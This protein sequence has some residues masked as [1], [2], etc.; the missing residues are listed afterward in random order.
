MSPETLNE[1]F[2]WTAIVG[3]LLLTLAV[4]RQLGLLLVGPRE[5]LAYAM[6]PKVGDKADARF[7]NLFPSID[8]SPWN[9]VIFAQEAC[10]ACEELLE[11]AKTQTLEAPGRFR[12]ALVLKG[13]P[14]FAERMRNEFPDVEM[15][16]QDEVLGS[17]EASEIR[18][19]PLAFLISSEGIV[20][21]KAIG[22]N[23]S[24]LWRKIRGDLPILEEVPA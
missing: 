15:R 9:L 14:S 22:S 4:Y 2:Q 13:A 18:A 20:Q 8:T 19:Y 21:D 7:L 3:V 6:G 16:M 1:F 23:G 11:Q 5:Y 17:G 24:L 12:L 10:S